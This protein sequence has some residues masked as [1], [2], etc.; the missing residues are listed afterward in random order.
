MAHFYCKICFLS[1]KVFV[2]KGQNITFTVNVL[3]TRIPYSV[4]PGPAMIRA[5]CDY[6]SL[7]LTKLNCNLTIAVSWDE[8]LENLVS[9][10]HLYCKKTPFRS[11]IM[12]YNDLEQTNTLFLRENR[13][14]NA[15]NFANAMCIHV[16]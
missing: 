12:R 11:E 8:H 3:L 13:N 10:Q 6:S 9:I 4:T 14:Q 15:S 2:F 5:V 16:A 1:L 7:I